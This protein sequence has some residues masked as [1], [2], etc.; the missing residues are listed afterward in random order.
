MSP[1]DTRSRAEYHFNQVQ[2]AKDE[3]MSVAAG[4]LE[5]VRQKTARLKALRTAK[6]AA[7][8]RLS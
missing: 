4:A 1:K 5:I 6:D 7:D 2:K 8:G 3:P